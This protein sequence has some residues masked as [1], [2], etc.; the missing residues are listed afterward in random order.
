[1]ASQLPTEHH[2]RTAAPLIETCIT[3]SHLSCDTLSSSQSHT[4]NMAPVCAVEKPFS[5]RQPIYNPGSLPPNRQNGRTQYSLNPVAQAAEL[6]KIISPRYLTSQE[7]RAATFS[8]LN[9]LTSGESSSAGLNPLYLPRPNPPSSKR[10]KS[11]TRQ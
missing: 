10:Q 1:M 8:L 9:F 6:E 4:V 7:A 5:I 2:R 3:A 11:S